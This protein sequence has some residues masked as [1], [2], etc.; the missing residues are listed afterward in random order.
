MWEQ[1]NSSDLC[2]LLL[3]PALRSV[4]KKTGDRQ[5]PGPCQT[6][7]RRTISFNRQLRLMMTRFGSHAA[8]RRAWEPGPLVSRQELVR[9]NEIR[10][11]TI[12][13]IILHEFCWAVYP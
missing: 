9:V 8:G 13:S 5:H 3:S 10:S 4:A 2:V 1:I 11:G 6:S 12:S 7:L